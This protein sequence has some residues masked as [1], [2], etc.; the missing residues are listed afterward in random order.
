MQWDFKFPSLNL[1][2]ERPY[3]KGLMQRHVSYYKNRR[4]TGM[5]PLQAGSHSPTHHNYITFALIAKP[6]LTLY[7]FIP[8]GSNQTFRCISSCCCCHRSCGCFTFYTTKRVSFL[9]R[10]WRIPPFWSCQCIVV[11]S[12]MPA[13]TPRCLND[14]PLNTLSKSLFL[15]DRVA[16]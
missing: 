6:T 1:T 15:C 2:I 14:A 7:I 11:P 13:T 16:F 10:D 5:F 4:H 9:W 3:I 8:H 12:W